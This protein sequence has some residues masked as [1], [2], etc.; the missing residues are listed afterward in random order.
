MADQL[1]AEIMQIDDNHRVPALIK[2]GDQLIILSLKESGKVGM[3]E[4]GTEI[5][6]REL[7]ARFAAQGEFFGN[8]W[9]MMALSGHQS[10]GLTGLYL[11]RDLQIP[12]MTE[13]YVAPQ[14]SFLDKLL[15][16]ESYK[17]HIKENP[18]VTKFLSGADERG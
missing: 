3:L 4:R 17:Q 18:L 14:E 13:V 8:A 16:S 11:P 5:E 1:L 12:I 6:K 10:L 7:G 9:T 15:G 2:S